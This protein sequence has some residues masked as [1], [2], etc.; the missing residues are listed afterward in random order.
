MINAQILRLIEGA[1]KATG[2]TV[3]RKVM[4]YE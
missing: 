3:S 4:P 2:L 1:R